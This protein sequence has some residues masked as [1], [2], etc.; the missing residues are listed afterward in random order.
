LFEQLFEQIVRQCVEAG[1]VE[2]E[3]LSVDGSFVEA[4]AAKQSHT[5]MLFAKPSFSTAT[6]VFNNYVLNAGFRMARDSTRI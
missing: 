2:G 4:N 3:H 5:P 6:P 1:L